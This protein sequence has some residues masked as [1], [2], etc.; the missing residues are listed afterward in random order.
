MELT[1]RLRAGVTATDLA[2]VTHHV[3][4]CVVGSFVEF[5]G[6]GAATLSAEDRC[7]VANMANTARRSGT[8]RGRRDAAR[9][10]RDRPRHKHDR[11]RVHN[12]YR[13]A[14]SACRRRIPTTAGTCARSRDNTVRGGPSL[15]PVAAQQVA[16]S[17]PTAQPATPASC[18]TT[19]RA[20]GHRFVCQYVRIRQVIT[21]G[22]I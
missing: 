14:S 5:F 4:A 22:L 21:A 13:R 19:T 6:D 15:G 8:F 7:T 10:R 12:F 17:L 20:R 1:G 16:A 9:L 3:R 2:Y 11:R 18:V